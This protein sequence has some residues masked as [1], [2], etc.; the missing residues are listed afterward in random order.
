MR[1]AAATP[2]QFLPLAGKPVLFHTL[3]AFMLALPDIRIVLVYPEDC[4]ELVKE[5]LGDFKGNDITLVKGGKTRFESVG[6]GLAEVRSPAVVLV[7]DAVRPLVSADLIRRCRRE[8][9]VRGNAVPALPLRESIR[10][11]K[12]EGNTAVD[13]AAYQ[14][15]QT[16]QA[17]LSEILLPAFSRPYDP[18]FTDEATVVEKAGQSIHLIPGEH[19]NIKITLPYDLLLAARLLEERTD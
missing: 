16:P 10:L 4:L 17:F 6:N 1:M 7:H 15:I 19:Q 18:S 12:E 9:L 2:K 8:A 13:R 3:R 14:V 11:V 5:V